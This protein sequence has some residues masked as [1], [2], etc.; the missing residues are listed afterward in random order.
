MTYFL[1]ADAGLAIWTTLNLQ[2]I[3][4]PI[5]FMVASWDRL[6]PE[7]V[8]ILNRY[9]APY[10]IILGMLAVGAMPLIFGLDIGDIARV[11]TISASFPAFIVFWVVTQISKK[12]PK[13]FKRSVFQPSQGWIGALFLFSEFTS[14]VG[15]FFLA[16]ELSSTVIIVLTVWV[17][18]AIAVAYYLLRKRYLASKG[19]DLDALTTDEEIFNV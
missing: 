19:I 2:V 13:A 18:I 15:V 12:Y 14:V 10:V 6:P 3:Q 8:E 1:I 7:W 11:A 17:A 5:S 4:L 9:G 16:Q